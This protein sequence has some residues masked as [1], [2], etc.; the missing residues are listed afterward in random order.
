[1]QP[2]WNED[3][4]LRLLTPLE[5]EAISKLA[6]DTGDAAEQDAEEAV[7]PEGDV[8]LDPDQ[9]LP[10]ARAALKDSTL[11]ASLARDPNVQTVWEY[12]F[13]SGWRAAESGYNDHIYVESPGNER[14]EY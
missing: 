12:N 2:R 9:V 13:Y 10:Q 6:F 4:A 7:G 14:E 11:L 5:W 8:P 3:E 1:M